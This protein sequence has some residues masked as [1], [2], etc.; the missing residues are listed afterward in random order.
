MPNVIPSAECD[1]AREFVSCRVDGELSEL[2]AVRL[3]DH[4]RE[5]A[6]C[7]AFARELHAL[8]FAL[9]EAPLER[10][11]INVFMPA[12]R[13]PRVRLQTAAAAAVVLVAAG[14]SFFIGRVIGVHCTEHRAPARGF[15]GEALEL[16]ADS[17]QQHVL[18]MLSRLE[19]AGVVHVGRTIVL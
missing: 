2:E 17:T 14:S 1:R 7:S 3:D 16:R 5:C 12:R 9:R 10:P 13:R 11:E 6:D 8:S 18:A 15:V 4:L 19:P